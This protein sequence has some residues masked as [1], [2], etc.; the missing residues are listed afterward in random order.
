MELIDTHCHLCH[1]RL[2]P[3]ADAAL[4]RAAEAGVT[5]V[6][7]AAAD[8]AEARA[9]LALAGRRP[10]L[11]CLAG[12]H[13]HHAAEAPE[14]YLAELARLAGESRNVAVGETGLD[15][16]YDYS[17]RD[18][19]RRVFAEQLD[20]ARRLDKPVVVHC[21]EAFG[22]TLAILRDSGTPPDRVLLHSFTEPPPAA[23]AALDFGAL[24]SF[25]GIVTFRKADD[26]QASARLAPADRFVLETDAPFLSPEPVRRMPV[27]EPANV[28]HV[29]RFLAELR[30]ETL[31]ALAAATTANA[32]RFFDPT[33]PADAA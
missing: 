25:S 3:Q 11:Y 31:D 20:L 7:C 22:D 21:R 12:V 10:N 6:L 30:G 28:R 24:L 32:V 2:R 19:Q 17:P 14:D 15:Y 9:A 18:V 26:V 1:G 13:P 4:R 8:L 27:N 29:A 23:R 16:H 5:T 33:P